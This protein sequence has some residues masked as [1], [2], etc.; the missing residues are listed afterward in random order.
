MEASRTRLVALTAVA[1]L[2]WGS[3]YYV[4]RHF[5][6]ADAP[7]WGATLR[8][9]PAGLVLL[10]L[11]RRLPTGSWWWRS[12]VL[13]L[14]N[15]AAFFLLVYLAA[16]LLPSSVAASVMALA[17]LALGGFGALLLAQRL[18]ARFFVA[19]V[20]GFVGVLLLV[21]LAT[22]GIDARGVAAAASALLISA[23]GSVLATRWRGEVP[24]LASTCWQLVA[25][26]LLLLV[27]A[28]GVEGAP[29]RLAASGLAAVA[30]VSVVATA[31]A[32]VLWFHGLSR[33]SAG[34]VGLVGL[35]NPVAGIALGVLLGGETLSAW[36][37]V[38]AVLVV[39]AVLTTL[40]P[41]SGPAG[42][43][44]RTRPTPGPTR[45]ASTRRPAPTTAR[46]R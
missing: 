2:T 36:Q 6:P 26:G 10:L 24:L 40:R 14:L 34:T 12:V 35:L 44:P 42:P 9:L 18:D 45:A 46:T 28:L 19:A 29:P 11:C 3:T 31:L 43:A 25:G 38:G 21:G 22:A 41:T 16:Q 8:A 4:T 1:P 23:L 37:I 39:G 30:Y 13:G 20:G 5:L 27:T 7:L 17:P 15:F 32:F 33:L